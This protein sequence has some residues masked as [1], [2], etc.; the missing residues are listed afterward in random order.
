MSTNYSRAKK[1]SSEV[2]NDTAKVYAA[3]HKRDG[4]RHKKND[5]PDWLANLAWSCME[6]KN[7]SFVIVICYVMMLF[8]ACLTGARAFV[9]YGYEV[10]LSFYGLLLADSADGKTPIEKSIVE[11]AKKSLNTVFSKVHGI[12]SLFSKNDTLPVLEEKLKLND[13]IAIIQNDESDSMFEKTANNA[14]YRALIQ[15]GKDRSP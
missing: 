2:R 3:L 14:D 12:K 7:L 13:G 5:F 4:L 6:A 11:P 10:F 9:D 8:Q 15:K 1:Q